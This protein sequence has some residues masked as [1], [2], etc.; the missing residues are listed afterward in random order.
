MT[1]KEF[2]ETKNI[3]YQT[4]KTWFRRGRIVSD[5]EGFKIVP[6]APSETVEVSLKPGESL[7][8]YVEALKPETLKPGFNPETMQ[9]RIETLERDN[10]AL[11]DRVVFLETLSQQS[12]RENVRLIG[13]LEKLQE[14]VSALEARW[15]GVEP[16]RGAMGIAQAGI[17]PPSSGWGA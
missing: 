15:R 12:A 10:A 1:L 5:G 4:A 11:R 3:N 7:K 2:A 6:P 16:S 9:A 17:D 8:P 14:R 13:W